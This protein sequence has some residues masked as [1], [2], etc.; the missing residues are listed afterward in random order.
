[1]ERGNVSDL[2]FLECIPSGVF[3]ESYTRSDGQKEGIWEFAEW[4]FLKAEEI[5]V[6]FFYRVF[7]LP[8]L[9]N[10]QKNALKKSTDNKKNKKID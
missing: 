6:R 9:R 10:A 7:E 2:S 3:S 8:L 5:F 1:V 4:M